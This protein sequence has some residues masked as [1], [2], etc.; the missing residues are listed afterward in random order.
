M[1]AGPAKAQGNCEIEGGGRGVGKGGV[2]GGG[3]GGRGERGGKG[4]SGERG[5]GEKEGTCE[6][7]WKR[8]I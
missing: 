4:G 1:A 6:Y 7:E 2:R 5:G 8:V 3:K